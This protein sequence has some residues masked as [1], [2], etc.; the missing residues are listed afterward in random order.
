MKYMKAFSLR[1]EISTCPYM[2]VELVLNDTKPFFIR[3]FPIKEGE[4]DII[5]TDMRN[6]CLLGILR[7]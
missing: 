3:T 2:E 6:G 7:K 1:A 4:K 5:D